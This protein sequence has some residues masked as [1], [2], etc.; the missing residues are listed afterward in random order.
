MIRRQSADV[1]TN[2]EKEGPLQAVSFSQLKVHLDRLLFA[3]LVFFAIP[4]LSNLFTS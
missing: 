1:T 3:S 4:F 2:E